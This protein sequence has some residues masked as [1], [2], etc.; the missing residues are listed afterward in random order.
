MSKIVDAMFFHNILFLKYFQWNC[1]D[2]N[3]LSNPQNQARQ[4]SCPV[5]M[6]HVT[7][8]KNPHSPLVSFQQKSEVEKVREREW[9]KGWCDL[10]AEGGSSE[11][12]AGATTSCDHVQLVTIDHH[13]RY[14]PKSHAMPPLCS[15][16]WGESVATKIAAI[17]ARTRPHG[18]LEVTSCRGC[19]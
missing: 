5:E 7:F 4:G 17:G 2:P 13:P 12:V 18:P 19:P 6:A 1:N 9:A 8:Y 15:S 10:F 3:S 16:T 11:N 14:P